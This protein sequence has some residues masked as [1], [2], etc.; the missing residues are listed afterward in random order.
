MRPTPLSLSWLVTC[1]DPEGARAVQGWLADRLRLD[2]SWDDEVHAYPS[3]AHQVQVEHHRLGD[4]FADVRVLPAPPDQPE[5]FAL[6]FLRRPDAGRFWKDLMVNAL[7]EL[8]GRPEVVAVARAGDGS[9][10]AQPGTDGSA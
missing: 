6:L 4:Y 1:R 7:Q 3:G 8:E 5:S 2:R 10:P 9:A